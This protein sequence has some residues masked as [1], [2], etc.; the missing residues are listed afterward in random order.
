MKKF[1][2][3]CF[4]LLQSMK[5]FAL[6]EEERSLVQAIQNKRSFNV[7]RAL[8]KGANPKLSF[9][10]GDQ[11][12][13]SHAVIAELYGATRNL[14]RYG[15][16]IFFADRKNRNAIDE[17]ALAKDPMIRKIVFEKALKVNEKVYGGVLAFAVRRGK[18]RTLREIISYILKTRGKKVLCDYL[19]AKSDA[20][21][22]PLFQA[23]TYC[24]FQSARIL[25]EA[26][27]DTE[28][29]SRHGLTLLEELERNRG[30]YLHYSETG[31]TDAYEKEFDAFVVFLR[32]KKK[33]RE[34]LTES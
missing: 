10:L 7:W 6:P 32:E 8:R 20:A 19:N 30:S 33:K 17:A 1:M 29:R 26:G 14:I 31:P 3:A 18:Y 23:G 13:L 25:I 15:S 34:I 28:I 4:F 16:D 22:T 5:S 24:D 9:G 2:I 12:A 21:E 27:A 11:S